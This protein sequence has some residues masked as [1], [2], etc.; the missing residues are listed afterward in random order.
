MRYDAQLSAKLSFVILI[1]T[2]SITF[3]DIG[4]SQTV[5]IKGI[6]ENTPQVHALVNA[7]IVQAPGKTIEKGT[8][9]LRDGVIEAVGAQITP[10]PDARVWNYEG[11]TIYPGLIESYSHLGLPTEK[12]KEP[13]RN[14]A[15]TSQQKKKAKQGAEHWNPRVHPEVS[16]ADLYQPTKDEIKKL[17]ALGFTAA[18]VVPNQGI[19]RG[20]SAVVNLVDGTPNEQILREN[21]AQ[22]LALERSRSFRDRTYP[23][24]LMGAIA[25]IRQTFLDA[26]WYLQAH[27]AY[28]LQPQGQTKPETNEALAALKQVMLGTQ[29][30]VIE[31]E[32]DL[33]LLRAIKI[34]HEFGLRLWVRG[35]GH[36]YRQIDK[37][38]AEG[39]PIILSVNF[40]QAPEVDSPEEALSVSLMELSH[41]DAAPENPKRLQ[42]AGIAFAL[43][44]ANLKKPSDFHQRIREAIERGLSHDAALAALTSTPAK[45]LGVQK[46]LGSITPGKLAHL[47]VTEGELFDPQSKI[48]DVWV[49]GKRYEVTKKPEVDP[50]GRW[51]LTINLP[52]GKSLKV[53]LDLKGKIE[54]LSGTI[55][56]DTTEIKLQRADLEHKRVS[57]VFKGDSL[58]HAGMIRMSGRVEEK[59]MTGQGQLPDGRWFKWIAEWQEQI[60]SEKPKA[61][62]KPPMAIEPAKPSGSP[63]GAYGRLTP[64]EQP[65]H[66]LIRGA[67]IWT[68]GPQGR[69]EN[70]DMLVTQGK[71]SKIATNLK[72][73]S[74]ALVIE[75]KGKHVTPG[76]IDAHSHIAIQGGVNE[77]TQAVTSEV[78]IADVIDNYAIDIYRQL[79]GGLTTSHVLHGSANPIGGQIAVI[80]LRWG[81]P[82]EALKFEDAP[83]GIKFALGENVKQSNWGDRFTTRYPQTRMGVEQIIRDRFKAALDYEKERKK[84]NSLKNKKGVIP[85]RRDL[86]L[87]ALLEILHGK[88]VV[89]S[90]SYRQDEILMLVRIA[91]DFGFTIG[92]FQHVL[93]GYK[94]AEALAQHGAGASTFSDW[95]AYKFEVYDAIPYN[96]AL[97]HD[98]GV[99]VSFN[100]DSRELAR[101]MNLEAAKAVKYGGLSEEEALKFVTL[102]PAKQLRI[103]HRVGSL[104]PGKDADFVIW[105]VHPLSTYTIC[106]QTWIEGRKYF[107]RAEDLQMRNQVA[108]ERARLIQKVLVAQSKEKAKKS[109]AKE[110]PTY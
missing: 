14:A 13:Q 81:A 96:G 84:Y 6:R 41:W 9:I 104:E 85:P 72:A 46:Q 61:E 92:A 60:K 74:G 103:D 93:E 29:P 78:R 90:H 40:P 7:R 63:P 37:M 100:S 5:P 28:G 8:V 52:E 25:L 1:L 49:N 53:E 12:K 94:V 108:A 20:S 43:S 17:R 87:E 18:L 97:M 31:V 35:S 62:E 19:F 26:Q 50:R 73:P 11:L 76:L 38:K 23:N 67:T 4:W 44:S 54:Q 102:N 75:A 21:V 56:K 45:L 27:E 71:I 106:E 36:E 99:V 80:K 59:K 105:S 24:S 42:Q 109:T 98:A 88:R 101:R 10:P 22:H 57:L 15:P 16:A 33:N 69:L 30:V 86:E 89:H 77:G 70:T 58:R 39:L 47:V 48:L 64:P 68:C 83:P 79:A 51:Q 110:K 107:D 65:R 32:D 2:F 66:V 82:A 34:A 3:M 91:E 55:F 95:W